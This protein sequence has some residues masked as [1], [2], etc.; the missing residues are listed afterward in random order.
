VKQYRYVIAASDGTSHDFSRRAAYQE[1][2]YDDLP[3]LLDDGWRPVRETPMGNGQWHY[4][5][6]V[7]EY[8][9]VLILLE[10]DGGERGR[11]GPMELAMER[12]GR[13]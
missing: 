12:E 9:L 10:K 6:K 1:Q 13:A 2:V 8:P 7:Y 3:S 5:G 4:K 11:E